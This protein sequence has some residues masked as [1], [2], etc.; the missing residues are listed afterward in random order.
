MS[1]LSKRRCI[2]ENAIVLWFRRGI[3]CDLSSHRNCGLMSLSCGPHPQY[4]GHI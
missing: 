4:C 1:L 2:A 3:A